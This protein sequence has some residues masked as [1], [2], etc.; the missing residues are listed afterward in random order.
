[1]NNAYTSNDLHGCIP[2]HMALRF[3]Y[4]EI[5]EMLVRAGS[6]VNA[7]GGYEGMAPLHLAL[8]DRSL[9]ELMLEHGGRIDAPAGDG[10]T[11]LHLAASAGAEEQA[12]YLL[13]KGA[14][15]NVQDRAGN[16][17]L[18]WA[19]KGGHAAI[20]KILLAQGADIH[21]KNNKGLLPLHY[22]QASD[23]TDILVDLTPK[24]P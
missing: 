10:G 6:D 16:T 12:R 3:R 13:G 20:C 4:T 11:C 14:S 7:R 23:L 22:A 5:A 9:F 2:L 8:G 18:H 19:A 1:V 17:P 15:V 21:I 24:K